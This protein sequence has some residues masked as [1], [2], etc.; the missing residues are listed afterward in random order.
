VTSRT[1]LHTTLL[2]FV[3]VLRQNEMYCFPLL[4]WRTPETV[5]LKCR[6]V[7]SRV[8]PVKDRVASQLTITESKNCIP[9]CTAPHESVDVVAKL[10]MGT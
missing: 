3:T 6:C 10:G 1:S 8:F 5:L 9:I 2:P 4:A 7:A